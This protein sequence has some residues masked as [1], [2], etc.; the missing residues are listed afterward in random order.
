[1]IYRIVSYDRASEQMRGSL[2][3]PPSL[4]AKVK[5]AAGFQP[6]DDGLGEYELDAAQTRQ[7]GQILGFTPEPNRFHYY[8]E[9][10]DPP[11]DS[12]FQG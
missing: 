11:D 6:Q 7:V 9:P 5:K 8:V 1:M 2:V 10:F 4:L 3:V 12:G